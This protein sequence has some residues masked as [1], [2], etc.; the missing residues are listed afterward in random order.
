[1]EAIRLS[2]LKSSYEFVYDMNAPEDAMVF[3]NPAIKEHESYELN[4]STESKDL[5][6]LDVLGRTDACLVGWALDANGE[7]MLEAFNLDALRTLDAFEKAR[8]ST[9]TLYAVWKEKG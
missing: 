9:E 4:R 6:S 8:K 5:Q 7:N 1:M 2:L 3:V